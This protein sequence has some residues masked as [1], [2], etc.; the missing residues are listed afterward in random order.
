MSICRPHH[1]P[2]KDIN[3]VEPGQNKTWKQHAHEKSTHIDVGYRTED[4]Y[5]DRWG[6]DGAERAACTDRAGDQSLI[7]GIFQHNRDRQQ[8]DHRFCGADNATGSGKNDT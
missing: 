2:S 7:V 5:N 4:H 6:N 3:N 1:A 8:A